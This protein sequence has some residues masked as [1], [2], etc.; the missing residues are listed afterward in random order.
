[1]ST[2]D[3]KNKEVQ[4]AEPFVSVIVPVYNVERYLPLCADSLMNQTLKNIEIIFVDDASTDESVTFCE[5]Y[6]SDLR[7]R[8]IHKDKNEGLSAARN[9]GVLAAKA[10]YI[11]FVDSDDWVEPG[12]CEIPYKESVKY[13]AD[14]VAFRYSRIS[15]KRKKITKMPPFS[16]T[17]LIEQSEKRT[18]FEA[19]VPA[20]NKLYKKSLL[21]KYPFPKG[22]TSEDNA[23]THRILYNAERVCLV[24]EYLYNYRIDRKD[25]ISN[26]RSEAAKE[27]FVWARILR[28]CELVEWGI[29]DESEY[30]KTALN[31]MIRVG[32]DV[33]GMDWCVETLRSIKRFPS[34]AS[35]AQKLLFSIYK[36]NYRLFDMICV[37]S[38]K[39]K[40]L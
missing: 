33:K 27:N 15:E 29:C 32:R 38:G 40:T 6:S 35:K 4:N 37:L 19:G 39:R 14:V 20:W 26:A 24:N 10:D 11:M 13:N 17:G 22:R 16:R 34:N 1:M 12:F 28:T 7:V 25:S 5:R 2:E 23:T 18:W 30:A 3:E 31:L 21:L 8:I 36:F 9:D